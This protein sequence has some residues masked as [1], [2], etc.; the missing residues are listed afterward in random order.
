ML[1]IKS[2]MYRL[3]W[4][5]KLLLIWNLLLYETCPKFDNEYFRLKINREFD[6]NQ[7]TTNFLIRLAE[8][9]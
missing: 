2:K 1:L 5:I 6:K 9:V 3:N 8:A 4:S 7:K